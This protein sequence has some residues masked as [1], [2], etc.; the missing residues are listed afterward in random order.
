MN[1]LKDILFVFCF[2]LVT[3]AQNSDDSQC[4][5]NEG[6]PGSCV[7]AASCSSGD[8]NSLAI[9]S[10]APFTL[11]KYVCCPTDNKQGIYPENVK[12]K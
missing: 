12:S 6:R 11:V 9:C 1:F 10:P 5:T 7:P 3:Y 2:F 8:T 4:V